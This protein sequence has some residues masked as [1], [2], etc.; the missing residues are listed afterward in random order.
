ML[1]AGDGGLA[2]CSFSCHSG[3]RGRG[4]QAAEVGVNQAGCAGQGVRQQLGMVLIASRQRLVGG[5][6]W[7]LEWRQ[8]AWGP[9][10]TLSKLPGHPSALGARLSCMA[11][12]RRQCEVQQP[13]VSRHII[14]YGEIAATGWRNCPGL[15]ETI[16]RPARAD[17]EPSQSP[18]N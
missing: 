8:S 16:Q 15:S 13:A 4:R 7:H 1:G 2:A 11:I 14:Q 6:D 3:H 10:S 17:E 18:A 9:R 5:R 12:G